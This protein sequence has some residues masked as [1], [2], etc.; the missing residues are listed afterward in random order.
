VYSIAVACTDQAANTATGRVAVVVAH[1]Q[2]ED[3]HE[4]A[5]EDED[6][7]DHDGKDDRDRRDEHAGKQGD[8]RGRG[9]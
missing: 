4:R 9:R 6:R 8:D 2:H 3:V 5:R 7:D 1:D